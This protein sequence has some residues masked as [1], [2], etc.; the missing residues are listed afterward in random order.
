MGTDTETSANTSPESA[1]SPGIEHAVLQ[2]YAAGAQHVEA[3]LCCPTEYEPVYLEILPREIIEKDYGCGNPSKHVAEGETVVDL[4]SGAGKICYI[5][6]QKVGARGRVIGVDFNNTMLELAQKYRDEIGGKLGFHNVDFKKGKIQDLALD[7]NAVQAWLDANPVTNVEQ[8]Q[9]YEAECARL[10]REEPLIETDT[11]DVVVSNCVLNLVQPDDKVQLFRE[12]YRVLKPGGRVVISDIVCDEHPTQEI[13]SDPELWSGCIAGAFREDAFLDMFE[14]A[15][16]YGIEIIE[17]QEEPW[18][19]IDGIEFRSLTVR[20]YKGDQ[21]PAQERHQ[22]VVYKG[23]WKSVTDDEGHTFLRGERMA[24]DDKTFRIMCAEN[25]PYAR[26]ILG[27]E[28]HKNIPPAEAQPFASSRNNTRRSPRE[29]KGS[30]YRETR[31]GG[32][33]SC[34][35]PTGCG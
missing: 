22:A 25:G 6:S 21:G 28:P 7:L 3:G 35:G 11:I 20:A 31:M 23:P 2:R 14:K 1:V 24:V 32:E 12:M 9:A 29:A 26:N 10:R 30:A 19:V 16:F 4:G 8:L 34:G 33:A 17:R 27:L 15:G 18:H 13:L 5:L